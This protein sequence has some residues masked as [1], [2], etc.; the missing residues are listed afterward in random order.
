MKRMV[1]VRAYGLKFVLLAAI[2]AAVLGGA[3]MWLWNALLPELF[4]MHT[5]GF[6]QALGLLALSRLLVGGL[7]GRSGRH[8]GWRDRM[9]RRWDEMT[10]EERAKFRDGVRQ[11]CGSGTSPKAG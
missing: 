8:G 10:E 4:G 11:R 5:I 1:W 9:A 2:A 6:W 7:R 3:V